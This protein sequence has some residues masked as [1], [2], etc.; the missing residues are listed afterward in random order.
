MD[1]QERDPDLGAPSNEPRV[2]TH[3]LG[4]GTAG[5]LSRSLRAMTISTPQT[6]ETESTSAGALRCNIILVAKY[7]FHAENANELSVKQGDVLKLIDRPGNGWLLV[8]FIDKVV[9]PGL[10]P[11]CYVDIALNDPKNPVTLGWLQQSQQLLLTLIDEQSYLQI[12]LKQGQG[13]PLTINNKPYPVSV[14]ILNFLLYRQRY[15]YRLDV[16]N[17]DNTKLHVCRYYQDFYN[18]HVRLVQWLNELQTSVTNEALRLPKLPEPIPLNMSVSVG[19]DEHQINLLLK[20]CNDLNVYINKLVLNKNYQLS[21]IVI[22]WLDTAYND[23]PGFTVHSTE[24][25]DNDAINDRMLPG[26]VNVVKEYYDRKREAEQAER[27]A[28]E[29]S[30]AAADDDPLTYSPLHTGGVGIGAAAATAG[31]LR[32]K[33]RKNTFNNYHQGLAYAN[34]APQRAQLT[35]ERWAGPVPGAGAVPATA[36]GSLVVARSQLTKEHRNWMGGKKTGTIKAGLGAN[37]PGVIG[38]NNAGMSKPIVPKHSQAYSPTSMNSPNM[39]SPSN[40]PAPMHSTPAPMHSTPTPM[41]S[42]PTPM[43]STPAPMHSNGNM[44]SPTPMHSSGHVNSP[45][46]STMYSSRHN[47]KNSPVMGMSSPLSVNSAGAM[48]SGHAHHEAANG[49]YANEGYTY[50]VPARTTSTSSTLANSS[51]QIPGYLHCKVENFNDEIVAVR[52]SKSVIRSVF[53]FKRSLKQKVFFSKLYIKMPGGNDYE[54]VDDVG[55][56]LDYLRGTEKVMLKIA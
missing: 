28:D 48:H 36:Q 8:K 24:P 12:L 9:A 47:S 44:N 35:K 49:H 11:A 19:D 2:H 15:W 32:N 45:N 10:V 21:D 54:N 38:A 17:S 56:L 41:H 30:A 40:S 14:L 26:S 20:R 31:L 5:S 1:I 52:L 43:H 29:E 55:G 6:Q 4:R 33:S 13:P 25:T 7:E 39:S 22:D 3:V 51:P 42:T 34:G 50:G 18:L 23:L 16:I 27:L 37:K 53:D 46:H